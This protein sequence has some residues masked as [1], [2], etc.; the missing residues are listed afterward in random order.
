MYCIFSISVTKQE[1]AKQALFSKFSRVR[2]LSVTNFSIPAKLSDEEIV[3]WEKK[4][5]IVITTGMKFCALL[6][7]VERTH[8][9]PEI[10]NGFF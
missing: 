2:P 8:R 10:S 9:E 1:S 3:F 5:M 7:R 4:K 6:E